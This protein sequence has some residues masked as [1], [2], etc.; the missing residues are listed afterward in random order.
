MEP[1][2]DNRESLWAVD[3]L[4]PEITPLGL[5]GYFNPAVIP[6]SNGTVTLLARHVKNA[7]E[8]GQ[9][10]A[11]SLVEITLKHDGLR[12]QVLDKKPIWKPEDSPDALLEDVRAFNN[13]TGEDKRVFLGATVVINNKVTDENGQKKDEPVT[14]GAIAILDDEG[15]ISDAPKRFRRCLEIG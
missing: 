7:A 3:R 8:Y 10:D 6:R 12:Y 9:P 11:G 13:P 4:R 14:Y 15:Q 5:K 2:K 1:L